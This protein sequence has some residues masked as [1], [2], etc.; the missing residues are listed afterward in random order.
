MIT[1]DADGRNSKPVETAAT[2]NAMPHQEQSKLSALGEAALDYARRGWPV[3]PLKPKT[4]DPDGKLA[5]NGYLSAK[6]DP[7]T[8]RG[9]WQK[10]PQANIG[11]ACTPKLLVLDEDPRHKGDIT[12]K[13][14]LREASQDGFET[15]T[16]LTGNG[17][18]H[19][20]FEHPPN[21]IKQS[22]IGEGLDVWSKGYFV[23]PPSIHPETGR[24][25]CW[26][27][28]NAPVTPAP[29]WL[30]TIIRE[31]NQRKSAGKTT[32]TA[33]G[34]I[35]EGQRNDTLFRE[36]CRLRGRGLT[37]EEIYEALLEVNR[38]RC[39]PP[40]LD[41]EVWKIAQSAGRYEP[42]DD[43]TTPI[44]VSFPHTD[45]GN[46]ER[47]ARRF[48]D[49]IRYSCPQKTW[50]MYNGIRWEP[51]QKGEIL[52]RAKLIAR[53]L[54][55]EAA[56]IENEGLRKACA[57]WARKCEAA[58][59]LRAT[60][61]CA[62]S[63][64][65]ISVL[66][67]QFDSDRFALNVLNGT[68]DLRTGELRP[69]DREN[70][71]TK[72][73]PVQYD[74]SARSELW[75]RFLVE[76]TGGDTELIGFLQRAAGYSLTGSV[77]E[78]VLFFVHGLAATGKSTFLEALKASFG[79]YAKVADFESFIQ[80]R[81]VGG[82][83][84]DIAELAGCRFVVSIEVDEGKKLAEGLV[85][86]L[87][88]GDTVRA[89]FL[90]QEAFEFPP[91][92]KLWLAANHAPRVK[93]DDTALW[94]RIL[95]IP[96]DHVVPKERRDPAVKAQL[97]D[98]AISGPAILAWAVEG[99]FRWQNEGLRVPEVVER[100]T[101][102]YRIEMDPLRQFIEDCCTIDPLAWVSSSKLRGAYEAW[103]K[104][105]GE[106]DLLGNRA[107][108]ERLKARGC[109]RDARW[110]SGTSLRGWRGIGLKGEPEG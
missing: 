65:N 75:E 30:L 102:Q 107:L 71:I 76:S 14:L 67:M 43:S 52:Q 17:G 19:F 109:T 81:E 86:M 42:G 63:E 103:A 36:G 37:V 55:Y 9:W 10:S 97:R 49:E 46:G 53:E 40:L 2:N 82:V 6:T 80:R 98:P 56:T 41:D 74:A 33:D 70:L 38:N 32:A 27:D 11:I 8:V 24:T 95:R 20:V 34:P 25:Y 26:Q 28:P 57:E 83:R 89:R 23:A 68:V 16:S 45:T 50:Y 22:A 64:P 18:R 110:S 5:P 15:L 21:G 93:D 12:L 69:H 84:N 78:E 61:F 29:Y 4:K 88:G 13:E 100:A 44:L 96:F 3:F 39:A 94:R 87:T 1:N 91:Q 105:D 108:A 51:D 73:A 59:R 60:L 79:S 35:P 92:F 72:L 48:A 66:P 62:Q 31:M 99:C 54:Y 58:D 47:L 101:E 85:K 7:E 106:K 90:Y 104:G 77:R